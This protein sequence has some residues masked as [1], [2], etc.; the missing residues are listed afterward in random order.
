MSTGAQLSDDPTHPTPWLSPETVHRGNLHLLDEP[1]TVLFAPSAALGISGPGRGG[2][3]LIL[4]PFTETVR[5]P[6]A[7]TSAS[8]CSGR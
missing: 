1:P 4:S 5:R 8:A 6:T 3:L 2:R 7:K